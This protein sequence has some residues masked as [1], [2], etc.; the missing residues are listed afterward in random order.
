VRPADW[1]GRVRAWFAGLSPW[2]LVAFVGG[3]SIAVIMGG[4]FLFRTYQYVQHDNDFCLSCHLMV[5]PY[6]RFAQSGHRGLGCK[7]CHQPTL[8][9]RTQMALAQVLERPE[10]LHTHAE[11]PNERCVECHVRGDPDRWLQIGSSIGHRVHFESPSPQLRGLQCVQCHSSSVHEFAATDRTCGQAGCHEDTQ[12][13]LGRMGQFTIHCVACHDFS[14]PVAAPLPAETLAVALSPRREDCLGCHQMRALLGDFPADEPHDGACGA[15]HDPHQQTTPAQAVRT[16]AG[17]GC[18]TQPE[19]LTPFHRGLSPG[20]LDNCT[21]CHAAHVFRVQGQNCLACHTDIYRDGAGTGVSSRP[22]AT[23]PAGSPYLHG[24]PVAQLAHLTSMQA[25]QA[26]QDPRRL[27]FRHARHRGVDCTSC[28]QTVR[29]HGELT[30]VTLRDCRQCHHTSPVA[31]QCSRC[32]SP[33]EYLGRAYRITNALRLSVW[34]RARE[35]VFSF[36]HRRHQGLSCAQCHRAPLTLSAQGVQCAACHEQHHRPDAD[37]R[38]CH[39]A[40]PAGAHNMDVH[41]GCAG[42][43][44]HAPVPAGVRDVPR[45]RPFCL[46]CHQGLD[47]HNPGRNC[48]DCHALPAPQAHAPGAEPMLALERRPGG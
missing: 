31:D 30:I 20:V 40:P 32:H 23:L 22:P 12:V 2:W 11:V 14:R 39:V 35:R 47:N 43:G 7:A 3:L 13:R 8:A 21:A 29:T 18:H 34:P 27:Q 26:G 38:S 1:P 42:A 4:V 10:E 17:A 6:E 5:E 24:A 15:C 9:V 25:P 37:C 48:V 46:S 36:D 28:H 41:V 44:C 16:C 33:A 45:T 19:T